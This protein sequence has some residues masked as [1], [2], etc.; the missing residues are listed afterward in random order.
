M[1]RDMKQRDAMERDAAS[2]RLILSRAIMPRLFTS[3]FKERP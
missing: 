2:L 3:L 1:G